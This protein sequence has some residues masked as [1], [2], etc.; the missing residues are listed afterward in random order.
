MP[1]R[2]TLE[3]S[4]RSLL[5]TLSYSEPGIIKQVSNEKASLLEKQLCHSCHAIQAPSED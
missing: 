1:V 5:Q 4:Y 3:S 2:L